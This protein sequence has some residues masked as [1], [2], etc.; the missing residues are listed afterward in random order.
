[1]AKHGPINESFGLKYL[2]KL[3]D[4]YQAD[5]AARKL[6]WKRLEASH[7]AESSDHARQEDDGAPS[8][9]DALVLARNERADIDIARIA[10][11]A[12]TTLDKAAKHRNP[13][14]SSNPLTVATGGRSIPLWQRAAQA[15]RGPGR[16]GRWRGG[17]DRNIA[18]LEQ[19]IPKPFPITTSKPAWG[20][21][22][23]RG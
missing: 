15:T 16:Q 4:P 22:G 7:R 3:G 14:R 20:A 8:V 17:M 18:A 9:A 5:L 6:E 2:N 1:M 10:E 19:V 21:M 12:K 23:S 13:V 11:L